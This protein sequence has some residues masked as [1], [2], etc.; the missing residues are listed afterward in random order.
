MQMIF[1]AADN[2]AGH[3]VEAGID[4]F[5][6]LDDIVGIKNQAA[7]AMQVSVYPNPVVSEL[8]INLNELPAD[9]YHFQLFDM[10]GRMLFEQ[11]TTN[12]ELTVKRQSWP[13][14]MYYYSISNDKTKTLA[15]G[16]VFLK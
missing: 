8:Q 13:T 16:K 1:E 6:V 5:Q 3:L 12:I 2:P 7:P 4:V 10:Y 15:T 11:K 9:N 14:G